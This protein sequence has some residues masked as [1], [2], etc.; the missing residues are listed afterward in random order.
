MGI[1]FG[2]NRNKMVQAATTAVATNNM[3]N[4]GSHRK[5]PVNGEEDK[6]NN[7]HL[8]H[9]D[10]NVHQ[11]KLYAG[12]HNGND[13]DSSNGDK[14]TYQDSNQ[15][16]ARLKANDPTLDDDLR[17]AMLSRKK[18]LKIGTFDLCLDH[19]ECKE[20]ATPELLYN[21]KNFRWS[22]PK[23]ENIHFLLEEDEMQELIDHFQQLDIDQDSTVTLE[24]YMKATK[25]QY[26]KEREKWTE[27]EE[28]YHQEKFRLMD[29]NSSGTLDWWEFLNAEAVKK[30]AKRDKEFLLSMLTNREVE[31]AR[32]AFQTIDLDKDGVITVVEAKRT[33]SHWF[34]KLLGK[35]YWNVD[36]VEQ[37]LPGHV[38]YHIHYLMLG[39]SDRNG[40]LTWDEYLLDNALY[41]IS[42]RPN[43]VQNH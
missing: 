38:E 7:D 23:C 21:A 19:G 22:C 33:F 16:W 20:G 43:V 1:V 41:F 39:D 27:V 30:L 34:S 5:L 36:K 25:A 4:S 32:D 11:G 14:V 8:P 31:R 28:K 35:Q 15:A 29:K 10:E 12:N 26:E 2:R 42:C 9:H 40:I 24:E 17:A 3:K 37:E 6:E 13:R 18:S